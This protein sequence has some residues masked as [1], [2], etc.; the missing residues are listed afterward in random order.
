MTGLDIRMTGKGTNDRF[1]YTNDRL[2]INWASVI[3][4]MSKY[5][6]YGL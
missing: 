1:G 6:K 4:V 3:D 5:F 2:G